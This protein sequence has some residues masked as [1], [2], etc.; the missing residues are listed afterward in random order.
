MPSR[1][2]CLD[3]IAGKTGRK[4]KDVEDLLD[5]ILDRADGYQQD[6]V[7]LDEA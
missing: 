6:G 1:K 5:Q 3:D 2:D 4:R 7:A